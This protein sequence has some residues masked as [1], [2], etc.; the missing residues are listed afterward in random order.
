MQEQGAYLADQGCKRLVFGL[1]TSFWS[2]DNFCGRG[3]RSIPE[4]LLLELC[5]IIWMGNVAGE[6]G[7]ERLPRP[8][9]QLKTETC[10]WSGMLIWFLG[11]VVRSFQAG[12]IM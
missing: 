3:Y 8:L 4:I 9:V 7:T 2:G 5:V 1:S 10:R 12:F 11:F 6:P